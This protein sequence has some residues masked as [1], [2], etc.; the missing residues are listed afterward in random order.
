MKLIR[1][2]EK[3]EEKPGVLIN[4]QRKDC[5]DYFS[6]WGSDFFNKNGLNK[7][8]DLLEKEGKN[9]PDI[10][11]GIRWA[12]CIA[13]PNMILCIGLNYADHAREAGMAL[14]IEPIVFGKASNSLSGPYD[15][16]LRAKAATK[17]DYE[18]ELGVVLNQDI[19]ELNNEEEA[20]KAIAGYCLTNDLSERNFQLEK[21]GQWIKGKSCPGFCPAGP[22]LLTKDEVNDVNNLSMELKVNG[23][24]RQ[25]GNTNT[26]IFKP[27]FIVYYLSQFMKMEAGDL[28]LTGTPPG[29]AMGMNPP[30][31][32]KNNDEILSTIE[33]LG[34]QKF[35]LLADK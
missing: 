11:S 15:D 6:D 4:H 30:V 20:E 17:V 29:V 18:I 5:S 27:A 14:P 26:M 28:I 10:A 25:Q 2:G 9:L 22:Y 32:L 12:S 21:G 24:V 7:L 31:Y 19:F 3:G 8:R 23:S 33:G 1:F 35:R 13:R 34:E 16:I